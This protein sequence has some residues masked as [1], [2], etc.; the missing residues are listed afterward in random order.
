VTNGG[1][2]GWYCAPGYLYCNDDYGDFCFYDPEGMAG[3]APPIQY[4]PTPAPSV[5]DSCDAAH[6]APPCLAEDDPLGL[7]AM[8]Q[9]WNNNQ[10]PTKDIDP[11]YVKQQRIECKQEATRNLRHGRQEGVGRGGVR[12]AA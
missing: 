8:E 2:N 4:T 6:A 9:G 3:T 12:A 7:E 10:G 1:G 5:I 11:K